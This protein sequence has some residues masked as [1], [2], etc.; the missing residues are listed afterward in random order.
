MCH[1]QARP[2]PCSQAPGSGWKPGDSLPAAAFPHG[3]VEAEAGPRLT[4]LGPETFALLVNTAPL[5]LQTCISC[6]LRSWAPEPPRK[7]EI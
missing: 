4:A 2:G 3:G 6:L 5:S 1:R 7:M